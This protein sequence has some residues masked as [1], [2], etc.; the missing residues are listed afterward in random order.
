MLKLELGFL[1]VKSKGTCHLAVKY[2][3]KAVSSVVLRS[4]KLTREPGPLSALVSFLLPEFKSR[5][6]LFQSNFLYLS[7]VKELITLLS[8]VS[9]PKPL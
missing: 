8:F 3:C 5:F 2:Q 7:P 9:P 6:L 1:L 4:S